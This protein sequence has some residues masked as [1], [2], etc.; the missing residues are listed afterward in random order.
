[1]RGARIAKEILTVSFSTEPREPRMPA[2]LPKVLFIDIDGVLHDARNVS[3][4]SASGGHVDLAYFAQ[5]NGLFCH[6]A[7]LADA[8][9]HAPEVMVI[10]HSNWRECVGNAALRELLGPLAQFYVGITGDGARHERI[11]RVVERL[12]GANYRILDDDVDAFPDDCVELISCD[13]TLGASDPE[14]LSRVVDW[15][16]SPVE[17]VPHS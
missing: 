16:I 13:P 8:L 10:V 2:Q 6:A 11:L 14:V 3:G 1:V 15:L 17:P 4:L 12:G 7:L 5:R 9:Q